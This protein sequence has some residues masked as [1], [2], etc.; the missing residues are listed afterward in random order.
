VVIFGKVFL[1]YLVKG[2]VNLKN[3]RRFIGM[4]LVLFMAVFFLPGCG[5][6]TSSSTSD[7]KAAAKKT[8]GTATSAA[9][10]AAAPKKNKMGMAGLMA[11]NAGGVQKPVVKKNTM[12][13]AGLMG[14]ASAVKKGKKRSGGL[15]GLG[16]I[17]DDDRSR[18]KKKKKKKRKVKKKKK[19]KKR[20]R[21]IR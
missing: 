7:P 9:P 15:A 11:A 19:K 1:K 20:V 5:D 2:D 14:P 21:R 8:D 13:L 18:K 12:G 16:V 4:F 10:A 3:A 6:D 17:D